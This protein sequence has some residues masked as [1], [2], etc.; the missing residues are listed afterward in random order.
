MLT[1]SSLVHPKFCEL[2]GQ[3]RHQTEAPLQVPKN[4]YE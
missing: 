4:L 1:V 2:E 3:I